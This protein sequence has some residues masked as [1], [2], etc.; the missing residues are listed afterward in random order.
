[1]NR[2]GFFKNIAGLTGLA[3][4]APVVLSS[5]S[6]KA[7]AEEGR[8]KKAGAGPEMVDL[9]DPVAKGVQYVEDGKKNPNSKG[10]KCSTCM[11]YTKKTEKKDGK[12]IGGCSIFQGKNV[13]ANGF[14]NSWAKKA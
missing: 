10:N 2:R 14:C 4:L 1:M 11:L 8:R 5:V 3:L 6:T 13:Y 12:E 9:N 7:F